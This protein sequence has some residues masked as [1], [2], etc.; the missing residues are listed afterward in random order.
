M[1]AGE[2]LAPVSLADIK[3]DQ[4]LIEFL[5]SEWG[6]E[7]LFPPQ[8]EAL[9]YSLSGRNLMLTIPTASGKS[10]VAHLTI[11]QRLLTDL[12][13]CRGLY[14]VPLKALASEKVEE[15]RELAELVGLT[16]GIAIGDR[17]GETESIEEADILVC[18]SEKLDSLLRTRSNLMGKI[19]VVVSDEFHLLHDIGRGPTLEVLLSRIRHSRPEAQII[20][21]SATVGNGTQMAEWLD[22]KLIES[23]WRPIRLHSGTLTG[24]DV[25][26]H[27]IDGPGGGEWPEPR[28]IEGKKTR[29]FQAVLDDTVDSAGQILIFV[30]SRA[31]AQKEARELAKYVVKEVKQNSSRYNEKMAEEWN[32]IAEKMTRSEDTSVM[33]RALSNAIRGGIA[34]HHAGLS[35]TQRKT[36][37]DSFRKGALL[38]IVATPTL[39]QGVNLPARRVIVRDYRRWSSVAGGS[40]PVPVMEIRQML[41]RAGRPKYDNAGDA[42]IVAKDDDEELNLVDRYLLS[43]AEEVTSKLANPSALRPEEDPALLTHLLSIIATSGIR[44]RD[45]L[46][47][48]FGETFL[49]TQIESDML[50]SR[51]DDVVNWLTLNE[52]ITKN[53]E[54]KEVLERIKNRQDETSREDENWQDEMPTWAKTS[55]SIPGLEITEKKVVASTSLTPRKGPAIFGFRKAS[56]QTEREEILP[57]SAA[58]T[59][60]ATALGQ[61]VA[62]LYLNPIS[63]RIIHDGLK[64]AM[65]VMR[66]VD[67]IHQIS[68]L[69]L[70]HLAACTPDFIAL[71]P[72]KEEWDLI[73]SA[74]HNHERE[75]L[76]EPV[77]SDQE[78]RMK[79]VLVLQE[80]IE[81]TK[82]EDLEN[83]WN[84]QPGDLRS[85]VDLAEWLLFAMREILSEDEELRNI[86]PEGHRDL[87]D[88]VSELHRRVR[89]GCKTEL[90]GL[91]TI[92]GVGRTRARE[93]MKLLGVETALDVASLTEKD[94]SKLADL[95]GWSPKL[96]SNIVAEAS[97]V[98][99]RR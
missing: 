45:A 2:D 91:V 35:H 7:E 41:G 89:Y 64:V 72:R 62:R 59:Y 31:S 15:L 90:L 44:D 51:I 14:I 17:G 22:A 5:R 80:W 6:I 28:T 87:V 34:F 3:L 36:I 42:W 75:F 33:G 97:R 40:M 84:V 86:D 39:A 70:L 26:V 11:I 37:E 81:E 12:E 13:G 61:R 1:A 79:G 67:D 53:G 47:R 21:L 48:F 58:M 57:D 24:L 32:S 16:V 96:V 88:A 77:D 55:S 69:G 10:L 82:M 98:S 30:N 46:S 49:A 52:M 78:R 74:I 23:D 27:R 20:A 9:P 38:A 43:D 95:R 99:R 73:N 19:G 71:W 54:S 65:D 29:K 68:P 50:E 66:G 60:E 76:A 63:G 93:M 92:R 18:T 85:R 8:Q 56:L 4:R 83:R 94:S 25:K